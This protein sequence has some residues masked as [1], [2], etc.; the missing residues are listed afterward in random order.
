MPT[1]Q[2]DKVLERRTRMATLLENYTK[3]KNSFESG[4]QTTVADENKIWRQQEIIYRIGV[5][6]TFQMFLSSVPRSV[7][8]SDLL[9]HFHI[10]DAYIQVLSAERRYV[11]KGANR[12]MQMQCET[13]YSS[14]M[15]VISDYKKRF[16]SFAPGINADHY[17][18]LIGQIIQIILP[19]WVQYRQTYIE[20]TKE[21]V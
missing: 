12:E 17:K 5:L 2:T 18:N 9:G 16:S 14:L 3:M 10:F 6:E 7:E 8:V 19:A 1:R 13:A 4:E 21:T 11:K 20:I 15:K